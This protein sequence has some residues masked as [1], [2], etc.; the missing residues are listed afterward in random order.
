MWDGTGGMGMGTWGLMM[1][2]FT[3]LFLALIAAGIVL[4]VRAASSGQGGS[5]P[6]VYSPPPG[7]YSSGSKAQE[8]LDERFARGEIDEEEYRRRRDILGESGRGSRAD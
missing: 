2:I 8:I 5:A 3:T 7:P 1:G 4:V 6:P